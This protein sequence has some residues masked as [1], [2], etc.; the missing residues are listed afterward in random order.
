MHLQV[1][2]GNWV[3]L[4]FTFLVVQS[5]FNKFSGIEVGWQL[6]AL[7]FSYSVCCTRT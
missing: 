2:V 3:V 5:V 6:G 1:I 7:F 4:V